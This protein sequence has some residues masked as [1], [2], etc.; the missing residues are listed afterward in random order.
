MDTLLNKIRVLMEKNKYLRKAV[1]VLLEMK[2]VRYSIHARSQNSSEYMRKAIQRANETREGFRACYEAHQD[3]FMRLEKML[4]DDLSRKTLQAVIRYRLTPNPD[5]RILRPV[6]VWPQ[7]FPKDIV[8]PVA[9][10][11]FIDG[12]GLH[13]RY[14]ARSGGIL[15]QK[16]EE[17]LLMGAG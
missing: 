9:D 6:I 3:E 12:G 2:I 14:I 15:G 1:P 13:W 11:V 10:E 4:E 8:R 17:G 16:L 5:S 7:Y